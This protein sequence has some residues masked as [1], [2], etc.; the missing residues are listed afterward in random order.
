MKRRTR[1]GGSGVGDRRR[2]P[3]SLPPCASVGPALSLPLSLSLRALYFSL[4][5]L[6]GADPT[7]SPRRKRLGSPF[8]TSLLLLP[9]PPLTHNSWRRRKRMREEN[10]REEEE[11]V[12]K[13]RRARRGEAKYDGEREP[14]KWGCWGGG[15][16]EREGEK[17]K[18][19][20]SLARSPPTRSSRSRPEGDAEPALPPLPP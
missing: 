8:T 9:R 10:E 2:L 15:E 7:P 18:R 13:K 17:N 12:L 19:A 5:C 3:L 11:G 4:S 1:E 14:K 16:G 6:R 20:R